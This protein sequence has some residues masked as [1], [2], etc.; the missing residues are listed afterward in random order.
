MCNQSEGPLALDAT[1]SDG[2]LACAAPSSAYEQPAALTHTPLPSTGLV[3]LDMLQGASAPS[4][5]VSVSPPPASG[6]VTLEACS[7][8]WEEVASLEREVCEHSGAASILGR[9]GLRVAAAERAAQADVAQH[10]LRLLGGGTS[11]LTPTCAPTP[12]PVVSRSDPRGQLL[13]AP[14]F[15]SALSGLTPLVLEHLSLLPV[16]LQAG[17]VDKIAAARRL[18]TLLSP[19]QLMRFGAASSRELASEAPAEVESSFVLTAIEKWGSSRIDALVR[20]W[21]DFMQFI[22]SSGYQCPPGGLFSARVVDL[23]QRRVDVRAR[24]RF[25]RRHAGKTIPAGSA[26]GGTEKGN[27]G[28]QL[29]VL[30]RDLFFPLDVSS[31]T[32]LTATKRS[33]RKPRHH[34]P[35]TERA[36]LKLCRLSRC[37]HSYPA[38]LRAAGFYA[39]A[40][41]ALRHMSASRFRIGCRP[42]RRLRGC[43]TSGSGGIV[44]G[45]VLI[46]PKTSVDNGI[47]SCCPVN[48]L[49]GFSDWLEVLCMQQDRSACKCLVYDDDSPNGDP[50]QASTVYDRPSS[51]PRSTVALH[52]LLMSPVCEPS[53]T[54]EQLA[55]R[56]PHSLKSILPSI[57][58]V[59]GDPPPETIEI[60][61]WDGS[62]AQQFVDE[63]AEGHSTLTSSGHERFS[64]LVHYTDEASVEEYVPR[65]MERQVARMRAR[66][67]CTSP[68]DLPFVGGF[69]YYS[70]LS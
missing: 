53:F 63:R 14:P 46:D 12:S 42:P 49:E 68:E 20:R 67:A 47:P 64:I 50:F 39:S 37:A 26:R 45:V 55:G 16:Q 48:D 28:S 51:L 27:S 56:T 32:F 29:R 23:Y 4:S 1:A 36:L 6:L 19:L 15:T 9:K 57:S 17:E 22:Q 11:L 31:A 25:L 41:N 54:R 44:R 59:G 2:I 21:L 43:S 3:T 62:T 34:V 30:G 8:A 7:T 70:R 65:I 60:G 38:R 24:S 35:W 33:K 69:A 13:P 66:V 61:K 18:F 5:S 52:A 10:R 58:R 40:V